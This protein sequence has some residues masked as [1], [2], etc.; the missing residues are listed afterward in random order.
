LNN[1]LILFLI[2]PFF[3]FSSI[4]S[5]V[6]LRLSNQVYYQIEQINKLESS[7][8]TLPKLSILMPTK[9]VCEQDFSEGHK[10]HLY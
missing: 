5:Y 8:V 2:V 4:Q 10:Q 6:L 7:Q 1:K 9:S 3:M